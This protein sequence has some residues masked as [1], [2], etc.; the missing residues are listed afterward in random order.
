MTPSKAS[1]LEE[2]STAAC[3]LMGEGSLAGDMGGVGLATGV[4]G[5]GGSVGFGA[6]TGTGVAIGAGSCCRGEGAT[7]LIGACTMA[8]GG[9]GDVFT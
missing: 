9:D 2:V 3:S 7:V 5:A 6:I 4:E 8:I 1:P